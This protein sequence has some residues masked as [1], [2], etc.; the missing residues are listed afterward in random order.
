MGDAADMMWDQD[1][2][3]SENDD[4][5]EIHNNAIPHG[6]CCGKCE[7]GDPP[8]KKFKIITNVRSLLPT[9]WGDYEKMKNDLRKYG[10]V[11]D[12]N[13]DEIE[14]P[15]DKVSLTWDDF[16]EIEKSHYVIVDWDR[17]EI[18]FRLK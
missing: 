3:A 9:Q 16:I 10:F 7:D 18:E 11:I 15:K 6:H 4:Y 5:C 13:T 14:A 17:M 8:M 1:Y 2:M 12:D